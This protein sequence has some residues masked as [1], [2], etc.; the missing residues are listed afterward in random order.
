MGIA[1]ENLFVN[2]KLVATD[3][4][5]LPLDVVTINWDI[6]SDSNSVVQ[7]AYEVRLSRNA[8]NWGTSSF[9]PDVIAQPLTQDVSRYWRIKTKFLQR[10][11][12]YFGQVR[13]QDNLG[14]YSAWS[15]FSFTINRLP[16]IS[17]AF[18]SPATPAFGDSLF[19][20]ITASSDS[21]VNRI[22]WYVNGSYKSQFDDFL[23]ISSEYVQFNTTWYAEI[24]PYDGTEYGALY[25]TKSVEIIKP[26][27]ISTNLQ[28]LPVNPTVND[29]LEA[30]YTLID[31]TNN[32]RVENGTA[33]IRWYV[34]DVLVD[35]GE[36]DSDYKYRFVR[37]D[38]KPG[39]R[40]YYTLVPVYDGKQGD[41]QK[42]PTIIMSD[43]AETFSVINVRVD[44]LRDNLGIKGPNATV[45]YDIIEPA[46][47]SALFANI[48]VGT[49]LNSNNVLDV[50]VPII[51]RKYVIT[52]DIIMRGAD[53]FVSVAVS[54]N[55][56][57]FVNYDAT[58]FRLLGN[59]WDKEV[60]NST[61][62]T[63]KT[64]LLVNESEQYSY[65]KIALSDGTR[66]AELRFGSN[67]TLSLNLGNGVTLE[68]EYTTT[69]P[70]D[71][72]IVGK[73]NTLKVYGN[74]ILLLDATDKFLKES[75]EKYIEV[76]SANAY[77]NAIMSV[78]SFSYVITGYYEPSDAVYRDIKF[79]ELIRFTNSS[80]V[81]LVNSDLGVVV[82]TNPVDTQKNGSVYRIFPADRT[83]P[84]ATELVVQDAV[85]SLNVS[86]DSRYMIV[87]HVQGASVFDGY[88][89]PKFDSENDFYYGFDPKSNLWELVKTAPFQAVSYVDEGM[90]ID[91]TVGYRQ[92]LLEQ[93]STEIYIYQNVEAITFASL[94]D[95]IINYEFELEITDTELV[96]YLANASTEVYRTSLSGK[97]VDSLV[98]ELN[99]L[100]TSTYYF[101]SLYN[102]VYINNSSIGAQSA[103][104]VFA[105][106]RTT[107]FPAL[108]VNGRYEILDVYNPN[109]Y[110]TLNTGKWYYTHRKK[111]TPWFDKVNN[112]VG[113]TVDIGLRIDEIED[114]DTPAN[115]GDPRGLGLYVNDGTVYENIWFLPQEI[116]IQSTG[117]STTFDTTSYTDYRVT[118]KNRNL[119]IYGKK[120][121]DNYY[122]LL[123][124]SELNFAASKQAN[125]GRPHVCSDSNNILHAVW[126]DD[127]NKRNQ[128]QIFYS[129]YDPAVG[130][131][132]EPECI[133]ADPFTSSN[134]QIAVDTLGNRYVVYE[135]TKTDYTD[136]SVIV[137]NSLSW[138]NPYLLSSGLYDSFNPQI[139]VD[140]K[141]NAHV[142][143]EDYRFGQ[144]QLFYVR[145]NAADGQ[146]TGDL[147]GQ[148]AL[149]IT[150]DQIGAKRPSMATFDNFV[151]VTWTSYE[152][153]GNTFIKLAKLEIGTNTWTSA[154]QTGSD[155]VVS[156]AN[157]RR[158]DNSNVITDIKGQVFVAYQDL[159]D[160]NTQIFGRVI[161]STVS[162]SKNIKQLTQGSYDSSHPVCGLHKDTGDIYVVFE[163]QQ[164]IIS[165][166]YDE[167]AA[168]D[169]YTNVEQLPL[170]TGTRASTINLIKFSNNDQKWYSSNQERPFGYASAFDTA[171]VY[172]LTRICLRPVIASSFIDTPHILYESNETVAVGEVIPNSS[173]FTQIKDILF[174]FTL[175]PSY[176]VL[177]HNTYGDAELSVNG[178][179]L[180]K[181]IRFGDFSDN[182]SSRMVIGTLNYYL[183]DATGPFSIK[184]LS[185]ATME[186]MYEG[187]LEVAVPNN[188][189]DIWL[190]GNKGLMFYKSQKGKLLYTD[191]S[192]AQNDI[193]YVI[194]DPK[195]GIAN[196]TI[197][198][199]GFD[200][201]A[202]MYV[203]ADGNLYA[204]S[205][206]SYFVYIDFK[207]VFDD[208]NF[209][210][211]KIVAI[212]T[213]S[214]NNLYVATT[215]GLC[216]VDM[217]NYLNSIRIDKQFAISA[218]NKNVLIDAKHV[219]FYDTSNGLPSNSINV[220]KSDAD[221]VV[222]IGT[223][224]GL[225]RFYFGGI[226]V[227]TTNEGLSSNVVNDI[228][229]RNTAIR[230]VATG[231]GVNKMLGINITD[232]NFGNSNLPPANSQQV[233]VGNV[234]LPTFFNARSVAWRSP[235][236]LFIASYRDI[237][238]ITYLEEAF[239]TEKVEI[240]IFKKE[241]FILEKK[242][243]IKNFL[244]DDITTFV[245][246]QIVSRD[247][248]IEVAINGTVVT[249][250][251]KIL[252]DRLIFDYPLF[253]TDLVTIRIRNDYAELGSFEQNR[254]KELAVGK[255]I[256]RIEKIST[257]NNGRIYVTTGGD[258]N[259]VQIY[260]PETIF[261]SDT[262][263]LDT[264]PPTGEI[265]I[266]DRV[267]GTNYNILI[268]PLATDADE[269][270]DTL[271][272]IDKMVISN[273]SNFTSDG[274]SPLVPIPF[275]RSLV[276][277]LGAVKVRRIKSH[278][279]DAGTGY[280]LGKLTKQIGFDIF[281]G[282]KS[283]AIIYKYDFVDKV[284]NE[285]AKFEIVNGV[286]STDAS[287][288]FIQEYLG[289][290]YVGTGSSSGVAKLY[291]YN[292]S[293]SVFN[294]VRT[295]PKHTHAYCAIVADGNLYI[296][297]GGGEYGAIYAYNA[298]ETSEVIS[299][300]SNAVYAMATL[301]LRTYVA[302]GNS[303]KIYEVDLRNKT[304]KIIDVSSNLNA[305]SA[306][307]IN[308]NSSN[309]IFFG[310][311][312]SGR[313]RRFNVTQGVMVP[314]L[315]TL[316]VS[317]NKLAS[318]G[319]DLYGA[320][321]K[322][323][324]R[325]NGSWLP[326]FSHNE[327]VN[328]IIFDDANNPWYISQNYIYRTEP[329]SQ[330][331]TVYLKLIDKAGNET[332]LAPDPNR[333]DVFD[334]NLFE[335]IS[336]ANIS[337]FF[338]ANRILKLDANGEYQ[339]IREGNSSFFSADRV[340]EEVGEYY[341]D[342]F[343]GTNNH[344]S[345]DKIF[346]DA[347]I[348][349]NTS[350]TFSIRTAK[351][352]D[353][354]YN[355]DFTYEVDG[356]TQ[357]ANIGFLTGQ[358]LQYKITLK[359][360]V[361][362]LTPTV[363]SVVVQNI[364]TE[365]THFF[366][367]N[368]VLPSRIKSGILTSTKIVPV[369]ADI[370]FGIN[371]N[372][373]TDF[374]DY[375]IIDENRIFTT[376]A[377]QYKDNLRIGI[378]F[379]SPSAP[380]VVAPT[381]YSPYG[382]IINNT[383]DAEFVSYN[384]E[385]T[386]YNI[387][388]DFYNNA[389]MSDLAFTADTAVSVLGFSVNSE[390][391]PEEG[392]TLNINE[393]MQISYVPASNL[394]CD[395]PYFVRMTVY[396]EG[397]E[398]ILIDEQEFRQTC[399]TTYVDSIEFDFTNSTE[400]TNTYHFRIRFYAN[401]ER[402]DLRHTAFSGNDVQNW[403]L[404]GGIFNVYGAELQTD[405]TVSLIYLPTA[406]NLQANIVYYISIDAYDGTEFLNNNNTFTY[407]ANNVASTVSCGDL[408]NV[409][410]VKN[411]ALM[412]E[413]ENNEFVT[414]KVDV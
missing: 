214:L 404:D 318:N 47:K 66:F 218:N 399:Q 114:S 111:G 405:E 236:I 61:G 340:D 107:M 153:G 63:I 108:T 65:A 342:I 259:T 19:L 53:Y 140:D 313:I 75:A 125:A 332:K 41:I 138:G 92:S 248:K 334:P 241:D 94:Y 232:L 385:S 42:S 392:V 226:V 113:W 253:S 284:W 283:P 289:K 69:I 103:S 331:K 21:L 380:A 242:E 195:S 9:S 160:N 156:S 377:K 353:D 311:A 308:I 5:I 175:M 275:S 260:Q 99:A 129:K 220:I 204:S 127:G 249:R 197:Q 336:L 262:I 290:L 182:I 229:I 49:T 31:Q 362:D 28:I 163:K 293:A 223:N 327:N 379:I 199:I 376:D 45:S 106:T 123:V 388:I 278:T 298:N 368:F 375:Q 394:L 112:S 167:Y 365:S 280:R 143:W 196:K 354:I 338:T 235:N 27:T 46:S 3:S 166:P 89:I 59:L 326:E 282:T 115:T 395:T 246:P 11:V 162:L 14:E 233:E 2:N 383:I 349:T 68:R 72:L 48:R 191:L 328:D 152:R 173:L 141:N 386:V 309:Y 410:V 297:C 118:G 306:A 215:N 34:N 261:A 398:S 279:F 301:D 315:N 317:I 74:N 78:S 357:T 258:V 400:T 211:N 237:Y 286:A 316:P 274:T 20:N 413:L 222:W 302:T 381:E 390:I 25:I 238:Q 7:K 134:P 389:A 369:S 303:G 371:T 165:T 30:S 273:Y 39:D 244:N 266:G 320:V 50:V 105:R 18:I 267:N 38:L 85:T 71:Y 198:Y 307:Q 187:Q 330:S 227:F 80:I 84:Y 1:I 343:N 350:I 24:T 250:G 137:G 98:A 136:I 35:Q 245:L 131:W 190:G 324:Y 414:L 210:L 128:R 189:G 272:G 212:A 393:S 180:R 55:K 243:N 335:S 159:V 192:E 95:T 119:K 312:N 110:G 387:R 132:T 145:R 360:K 344:V 256:T 257:G 36:Q 90:V 54:D 265:L 403:Y 367:T 183:A 276:H 79:V 149:R 157:S 144:A 382:D 43:G 60:D 58:T 174:D 361:R 64:S 76:G 177:E 56:N 87:T 146:W 391:V 408:T 269:V 91:T 83:I 185:N 347:T 373:S 77:A 135:T 406:L 281:A 186:K 73:N 6:L 333:P 51:D 378:K 397:F 352:K 296:G 270:F 200:K 23:E 372:N 120:N 304:Q 40:I 130:Y 81:D 221:D 264:E 412:F 207:L 13:L 151:Y 411:F 170:N 263:I 33:I 172:D 181:E 364:T 124:D 188:V 294:L 225:V 206:H 154:A 32:S 139:V 285:L 10:G 252:S 217:N 287:I 126:H 329:A 44:G 288:E 213:D 164:E 355:Q 16:F 271:S 26:A 62:W 230:Y 239:N 184:L 178:S 22:K 168:S 121:T 358:F 300:L 401:A 148:T 29:I 295:F 359:S 396:A 251:F 109:P 52:N 277:D 224:S 133:V 102:E 86:Q 8:L 208:Q 202:N 150:N 310:Y 12:V 319:I 374:A 247:S 366:T 17:T 407:K 409:P 158:A 93:D 193:V 179:L 194:E 231:S 97:N 122:K 176:N 384:S 268:E 402:T 240:T 88:Y 169:A 292:S 348:P 341:S 171:F 234:K 116:I 305:I 161:A 37:F 356:E 337:E 15:T 209:L 147:Y 325:Y 142:I 363:R 205:D 201:Q 82:A 104:R 228:A 67:N 203:V 370:I 155:F 314:S 57:N 219:K 323:V 351:T 322:T 100:D 291:V 4:I 254:A 101:F 117:Y 299:N 345:W 70:I 255:E 216:V 346:W 339:T 96:I 321:G